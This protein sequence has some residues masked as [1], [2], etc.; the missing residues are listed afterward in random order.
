[1]EDVNVE[2]CKM[3]LLKFRETDKYVPLRENEIRSVNIAYCAWE[4]SENETDMSPP[5]GAE[6]SVL[7]EYGDFEEVELYRGPR[8]VCMGVLDQF[9]DVLVSDVPII[10]VAQIVEDSGGDPAWEAETWEE[11]AE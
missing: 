9:A 4:I 10:D 5:P 1:M 8:D 7:L 2:E 11:I 6:P 3:R